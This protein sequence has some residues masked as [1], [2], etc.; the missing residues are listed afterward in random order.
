M[1]FQETFQHFMFTCFCD[2]HGTL[3]DLEQLTPILM[4]SLKKY[5]PDLSNTQN[6]AVNPQHWGGS[7]QFLVVILLMVRAAQPV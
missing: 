1:G 7:C 4:R 2:S 5:S 6:V 3:L